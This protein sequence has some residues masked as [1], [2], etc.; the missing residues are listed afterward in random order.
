MQTP[1]V[2]KALSPS[3][4]VASLGPAPTPDSLVDRA[5][6]AKLTLRVEPKAFKV[7]E[8]KIKS[9]IGTVALQD[10]P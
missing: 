7:Y 2:P 3:A 9:A 6:L 1:P 5:A 10:G 8:R 4:M